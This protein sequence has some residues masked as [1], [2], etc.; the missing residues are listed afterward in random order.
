MSEQVKTIFDS[1]LA[2]A[3]WTMLKEGI[4]P[5]SDQLTAMGISSAQAQEYLTALKTVQSSQSSSNSSSGV[6][7]TDDE[8]EP[9]IDTSS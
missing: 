3:G 7:K 5:S 8:D 2:E 9:E 4:L 1:D 6:K